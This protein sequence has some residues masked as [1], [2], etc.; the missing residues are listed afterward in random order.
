MSRPL[1]PSFHAGAVRDAL[2][3]VRVLFALERDGTDMT[4][5]AQLVEIGKTLAECLG[6]A[7]R[8]PET[9]GYRAAVTRSCDAVDK[10]AAMEWPADVAEVRRLARDRVKGVELKKADARDVK[11]KAVAVR[12]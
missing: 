6:L 9:L 11:R 1:G 7:M 4:R 8:D 12:G 10:L 3:L 2:G 5:T